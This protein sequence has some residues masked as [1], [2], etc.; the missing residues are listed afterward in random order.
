MARLP[1]LENPLARIFPPP[2]EMKPGFIN[3]STYRFA[4]LSDLK[5]LREEL[6]QKCLDWN[7]KGTI[8]LSTEGINLFVAG[9]RSE[10]ELLLTTLRQV[11]GLEGLEP[12]ISESREQP[13]TR[14]LVRIKKEIIAFGIDGIEPH[15]KTSPKLPPKELKQWLDEG[16]DVTLIDVRND[17]EIKLGTFRESLPAGTRHFR[18]FPK[19]VEQFPESLKSRPL[20]LFCTGGIR[21]EKAAPY[22]ERAGFQHIFQLDGGILKYFEECGNAHY[23]GDCFVFDKRVGVDPALQETPNS[24]CFV[25]LTPLTPEDQ[26]DPRYQIGESCGYCYRSPEEK[27]Q[28]VVRGRNQELLKL[29]ETLPGSAPQ[30]NRRP[31]K[32]SL[33]H[34]GVTLLEFLCLVLKHVPRDTWEKDLQDGRFI[35][36]TGNTVDGQ[37]PVR[38]GE[39]YFH[40]TPN[41]R[42]PDVN[43]RIQILYEDQALIVLNKPAPLPVHPCGRY[44]RNTLKGILD[45]VYAPLKPRPSHRLDANTTGLMIAA[46]TRHFAGILQTQFAESRVE[47]RYLALV[48]GT[49]MENRFR[50]DLPLS[51]TTMQAGAREAHPEGLPATTEFTVLRKFETETLLEVRPI[52]GRT[53]QIRIHLWELGFP[54]V[55]DPLY[56]KDRVLGD[57]QTLGTTEAPMCLHASHLTLTHPL[58]GERRDFEAPPPHWARSREDGAFVPPV[59]PHFHVSQSPLA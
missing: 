14:M 19:S 56:L 16:R 39:R 7:L 30:E 21:C 44:N 25:C 13:F 1:L 51:E 43:A 20:V 37:K 34:D 28:T 18:D 32:V 6:T 45:K 26:K 55:G 9:R 36:A 33:A 29:A 38:A 49:A 31:I 40:V 22:M 27:M 57:H 54:I 47:K 59:F 48:H 50:C 8:L 23:D 4:E 53:N 5:R 24:Q 42:E 58:T 17:Y 15:R 46:T 10:M 52:T 41:E 35:D 12:K 2:T 11:P 3:I